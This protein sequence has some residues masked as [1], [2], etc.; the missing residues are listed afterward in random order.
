V[1]V[2]DCVAFLENEAP[3]LALVMRSWSAMP[4]ALKAGIVAMAR[5]TLTEDS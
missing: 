2:A 4:D 1:S 3:D 5:A